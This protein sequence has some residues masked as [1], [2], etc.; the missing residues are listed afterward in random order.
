[1]LRGA[2][3]YFVFSPLL[4]AQ[5]RQQLPEDESIARLATV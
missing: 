1:M 5:S 3:L 2:K 4:S